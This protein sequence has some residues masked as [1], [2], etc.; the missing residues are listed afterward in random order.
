M[1]TASAHYGR[2]SVI[3]QEGHR[4]TWTYA[5]IIQAIRQSGPVPLPPRDRQLFIQILEQIFT[6][7]YTLTYIYKHIHI[8]I[9]IMIFWN[10]SIIYNRISRLLQVL[11]KKFT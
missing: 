9:W 8:N 5:H 7:K 2:H 11:K 6:Y 10:N 1:S 4:P 3:F